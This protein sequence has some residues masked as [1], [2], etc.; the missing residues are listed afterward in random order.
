M[1]RGA[2]HPPQASAGAVWCGWW[3]VAP[4]ERDGELL[5]GDQLSCCLTFWFLCHLPGSSG[6][7]SGRLCLWRLWLRRGLSGE[8]GC[9]CCCQ[10]ICIRGVGLS[11]L[12][13]RV[14][15]MKRNPCLHRCFV[16]FSS[17]CLLLT[18]AASKWCHSASATLATGTPGRAGDKVC[19]S[20]PVCSGRGQN[21]GGLHCRAR[22]WVRAARPRQMGT[23]YARACVRERSGVGGVLD[24]I[25]VC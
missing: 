16:F 19:D 10:S 15:K 9:S 8:C 24:A 6:G 5:A 20:C 4:R 22:W 23:P 1:A 21:L 18:W 25:L 13:L 2:P 7:C 14:T 11:Y 3:A 12:T 17:S